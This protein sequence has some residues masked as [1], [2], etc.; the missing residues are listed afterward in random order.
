MR[1]ASSRSA[2]NSSL[3]VFPRLHTPDAKFKIGSAKALL[4]DLGQQFAEGTTMQSTII[5]ISAEPEMRGTAL[6]MLGQC[7]GVAAVGGLAVG[8]VANFFSA[9]A[10]VAMSVSLGLILLV[11]AVFFSPLVRRPVTP[12]VETA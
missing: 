5:L 6:G 4:A 8:V 7:I 9:Q 2:R 12:P 3:F 1:F 10:A 11:P